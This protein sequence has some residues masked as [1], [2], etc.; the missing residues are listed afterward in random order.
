MTESKGLF[1]YLVIV[2]LSKKKKH[3]LLSLHKYSPPPPKHKEDHFYLI[4]CKEADKENKIYRKLHVKDPLSVARP[5][6][7]L[8]RTK[9]IAG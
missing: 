1:I 9:R 2:T 3:V 4:R 7:V 6:S 5:A 8:H